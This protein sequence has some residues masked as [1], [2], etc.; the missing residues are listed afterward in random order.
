MEKKKKHP[1]GRPKLK[2]YQ[3]RTKSCLVMFNEADYIY[4]KDKAQRAG[5]SVSEFCH[6]AAMD[7][8]LKERIQPEQAA[9]IRDIAGVANNVN[10]I[11]HKMHAYGLE[12][13][14]HACREIIHTLLT[15]INESK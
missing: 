7:E 13:N 3:K 5:I 11:A 8:K 14:Y 1:G 12:E 2:E 10:Q 4:I 9:L 6:R 15:L